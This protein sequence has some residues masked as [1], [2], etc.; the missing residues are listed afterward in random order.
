ME[1]STQKLPIYIDQT[2]ITAL[3]VAAEPHFSLPKSLY[4]NTPVPVL[5]FGTKFFWFPVL[6]LFSVPPPKKE[7]SGTYKKSRDW[8]FPRL[9]HLTSH[10]P[11]H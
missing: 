2:L 7:I 1:S 9:G 6:I 8:E 3:G 10:N 4:P 11:T 5:I